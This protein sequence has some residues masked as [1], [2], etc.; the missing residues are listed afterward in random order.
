VPHLGRAANIEPLLKSG[1]RM[2]MARSMREQGIGATAS[3]LLDGL[4]R[5]AVSAG[6]VAPLSAAQLAERDR[7]RDYVASHAADDDMFAVY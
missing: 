4:R 1:A 3:R 5:V 2:R 7:A 6:I